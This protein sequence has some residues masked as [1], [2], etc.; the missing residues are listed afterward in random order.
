VK[1]LKI[2]LL[3]S[4]LNSLYSHD[5]GKDN[6]DWKQYYRLGSVYSE[7]SDMGYTGYGRLKRTT[8]LTFRDIR[9]F[10]HFFKEDS[11]IRLRHKYSRR[12]LSLEK[13]YSYS[14]LI[15]EKNTNLNVKLRYHLNQGLGYFIRKSNSGNI[16]LEL[17]VAFDNSDYLNTE[18]KTTYI[19]GGFSIDQ[20]VKTFSTK[21]EV[22]YFYQLSEVGLNS[23]LSRF[24]ILGEAKWSINNNLGV[25]SG[26][27]WD[28]QS[29][30]SS[31]SAFLTLSLIKPV[32]WQL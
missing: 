28:I 5:P 24:Q 31:P 6:L 22:D 30:E 26:F 8:F 3:A 23:S 4:M 29:E 9:F 25:I 7:S 15:Y 20:A 13:I 1:I 16:T 10:G 17:G 32:T 27:T 18:Q 11:E 12:F 2:V 14:T 19:R 21:F